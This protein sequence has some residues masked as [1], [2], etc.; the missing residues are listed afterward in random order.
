MSP[1]LQQRVGDLACGHCFARRDNTTK[2][3]TNTDTNTDA[4]M[5]EN[6][7]TDTNTNN[8]LGLESG[9]EAAGFSLSPP[10][11]SG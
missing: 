7:N 10:P 4:N 11:E 1:A 9:G 3:E 8:V 2:T 6:K 5:A